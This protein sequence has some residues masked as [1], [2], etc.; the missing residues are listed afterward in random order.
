MLLSF[1]PTPVKTVAISRML[2]FASRVCTPMRFRKLSAPGLLRIKRDRL[3]SEDRAPSTLPPICETAYPTCLMPCTVAPVRCE[4]QYK[5]SSPLATFAVNATTDSAA[6]S[7]TAPI[8]S[9][10]AV[11]PATTA[12]NFFSPASSSSK[13]RLTKKSLMVS[14][15]LIVGSPLVYFCFVLCLDIKVVVQ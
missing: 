2:P 13:P 7:T 8:L 11:T 6:P 10:L 12:E 14:A 9:T 1:W 3:S 15:L 4:A 5:L